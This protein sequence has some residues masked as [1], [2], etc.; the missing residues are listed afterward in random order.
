[1]WESP[2]GYGGSPLTPI[3]FFVE[4]GGENE[5]G[6][7]SCLG[8]SPAGVRVPPPTLSSF[9]E[10]LVNA[11]NAAKMISTEL[12]RLADGRRAKVLASF[13]KTG[14]GEYGE[15]DVFYG[16][17]VPVVRGVAGKFAEK[18]GFDDVSKLLL[19]KIHEERLAALLILVHKFRHG[20]P[21]ERKVIYD[22]YLKNTERVNNWDLVDLSAEKIVGAYLEGR[23]KSVLR[24]LA[25]SGNPWE[26]RIS[27]IATFHFIKKG[28]ANQTYEIAMLLLRDKH[29]LIHKAVG[30]MLREAGKRCSQ[31]ELEGFLGK[32]AKEM[33]RTMLRYAIERL[34]EAKRRRFLKPR[35]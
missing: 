19:S 34:P 1:M 3:G 26:R 2:S 6:A 12:R 4:F 17:T 24:R 23:D 35:A 9:V 22:Y 21:A 14:W 28:D 13:F 27:I 10:L 8:A 16:V 31:K 29:D 30:W 5:C 33:P 18:A 32:H 11:M 15:G 7:A 25:A 20:N